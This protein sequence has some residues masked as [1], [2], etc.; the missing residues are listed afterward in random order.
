MLRVLD[1]LSAK[2]RPVRYED[3]DLEDRGLRVFFLGLVGVAL[4]G[5]LVGLSIHKATTRGLTP[6]TEL[7]GSAQATRALG[8]RPGVR[9][10]ACTCS[11]GV[12]SVSVYEMVSLIG[13]GTAPTAVDFT[14]WQAA[15]AAKCAALGPSAAL[16]LS[17]P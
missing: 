6:T 4:C 1:L 16:P 17:Q 10:L 5:V 15:F 14:A 2:L 8:E 12:S 9:S 3:R 7:V 13:N 11:G